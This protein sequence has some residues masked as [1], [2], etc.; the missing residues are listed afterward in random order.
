MRPRV[1]MDEYYNNETTSEYMQTIYL[2]DHEWI[3]ANNLS[4]PS[5]DK[6]LNWCKTHSPNIVQSIFLRRYDRAYASLTSGV[7]PG[8]DA[9]SNNSLSLLS[10][11]EQANENSSLKSKH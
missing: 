10:D 2:R 7:K 9:L 6:Q 11:I 4:P 5:S 8:Y 3:Y 1:Y